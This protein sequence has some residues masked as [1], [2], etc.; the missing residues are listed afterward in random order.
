M[1]SNIRRNL[2]QAN[3]TVQNMATAKEEGKDQKCFIH[4]Q[5][6]W[7]SVSRTSVLT[8]LLLAD[9]GTTADEVE[10]NPMCHNQT[11]S[12]KSGSKPKN[13]GLLTIVSHKA[14]FVVDDLVLLK[15]FPE[16]KHH[17]NL[18]SNIYRIVERKNS[19]AILLPLYGR[20]GFIDAHI[21]FLKPLYNSP[22]L[23][24]A[25]PQVL[26][27]YFTAFGRRSVE[28]EIGASTRAGELRKTTA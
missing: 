2:F 8:I 14:Q 20:L 6:R 11:S 5:C 24:A 7:F 21:S 3:M 27:K 17:S 15:R 4:H 22:E 23:V 28:H 9:V 25:L 26:R 12:R 16:D 18:P 13:K 19:L 10:R 1:A